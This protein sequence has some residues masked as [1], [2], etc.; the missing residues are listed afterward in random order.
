MTKNVKSRREAWVVAAFVAAL[1]IG[2]TSSARAQNPP[3]P[4]PDPIAITDCVPGMDP[5]IWTGFCSPVWK[6]P[7]G[8]PE[9]A[10]G[11]GLFGSTISYDSTSTVLTISATIAHIYFDT[12]GHDAE[13]GPPVNVVLRVKIGND[14]KFISGAG[15]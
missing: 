15:D 5:S 11:Q 14:G 9:I 2:V 10:F 4:P 13:V 1:T 6:L 12:H 8:T 3:P 7:V